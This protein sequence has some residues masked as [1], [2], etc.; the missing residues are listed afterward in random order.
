MCVGEIRRLH[1]PSNLA[2]GKIGDGKNVSPGAD[3]IYDVE[4]V[5]P[6]CSHFKNLKMQFF[7]SIV[8]FNLCTLHEI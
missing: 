1:I 3:L 6:S 8:Q 2:Y 7:H 5:M 4:V